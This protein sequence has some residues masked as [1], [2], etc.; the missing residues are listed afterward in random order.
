MTDTAREKRKIP[1]TIFAM[2]K[3]R[4][5]AC[6]ITPHGLALRCTD[7]PGRDTVYKLSNGGPPAG[8]VTLANAITIVEALGGEIVIRWGK[9]PPPT[10]RRGRPRKVVD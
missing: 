9:K 6:G 10:P 7:G 5:A 4:L 2:I 3:D 8:G 1:A